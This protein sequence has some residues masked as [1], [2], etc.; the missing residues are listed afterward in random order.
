MLPQWEGLRRKGGKPGP[1]PARKK[2]ASHVIGRS[3]NKE[4]VSPTGNYGIIADDKIGDRTLA[5]FIM[6]T[7]PAL[8]PPPPPERVMVAQLPLAHAAQD[9]V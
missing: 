2:E 5:A 3:V 7:S 1:S 9:S 6:K 8:S 4:E